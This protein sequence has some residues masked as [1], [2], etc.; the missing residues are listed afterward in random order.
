MSKKLTRNGARDVTATFDRMAD[1]VQEHCVA[2]G[3][4]PRIAKDLAYRI[5]LVSD[6]VETTATR[7]FPLTASNEEGM[8]LPND[9]WDADQIADKTTGPE[10]S[11]AD[12]S[13]MSTFDEVEHHE[14]GDKEESGGLGK[15][16]ASEDTFGFNLFN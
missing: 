14:L 1:L 7:N 15:A 13:Y 3:I 11:D 2:L 8:S 5:D 12:E 16:A 6:A 4:E 9:G 10:Q